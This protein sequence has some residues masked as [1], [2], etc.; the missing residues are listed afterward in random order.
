MHSVG[1]GGNPARQLENHHAYNFPPHLQTP[2][3]LP[4]QRWR[5][6]AIRNLLPSRHEATHLLA[7]NPAPTQVQPR[8]RH[9]L[10][11]PRVLRTGKKETTPHPT[12]S[13]P[14]PL[15]TGV[16]FHP[17]SFFHFQ[18]GNGHPFFASP[19]FFHSYH[20]MDTLQA[21]IHAASRGTRPNVHIYIYLL[22]KVFIYVPVHQDTHTNKNTKRF[23]P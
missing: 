17:T 1:C 22:R 13:R 12:T 21:S 19:S 7:N 15:K 4:C 16:N 3:N 9:H 23:R 18:N 10:H 5:G 6:M 14:V 20:T 11:N 8:H 2:R